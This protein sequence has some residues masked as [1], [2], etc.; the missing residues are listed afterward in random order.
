MD[1]A[2]GRV[3]SWRLRSS[4]FRYQV[5]TRPGREHHFADAMS[6]LPTLAPDRSVIPEE[7]SCLSLDNSSSGGFAPNYG[8]LDKEQPVTLARMLPAQKGD[9]RCQDPR[10][11]MDQNQHTRFS[12]TKERLLVRVSPLYRAFQVYVPCILRQ[13]LLRLEHNVM[14]AGHPGVNRMYASIRRHY[15]WESM[16]ADVYDWVA[17]CSSCSQ[18]R[19]APRRR[20]AMLNSF[21][22]TDLFASLSMDLLGPLTETKTGNVFLLIIVNRFSKLLRAVPLAGITATDV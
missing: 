13:D 4:E 15:Y 21:P 16:V 8:E 9:Q 18:N 22:A 6:R 19:I 20:T 11:K 12:E 2:Q 5:C 3:A 14:R 17:S 1:S 7:I 10:D